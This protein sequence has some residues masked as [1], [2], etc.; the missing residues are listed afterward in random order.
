MLLFATLT[1][2]EHPLGIGSYLRSTSASDVM[3]VRHNQAATKKLVTID[4]SA[5]IAEIVTGTLIA[6]DNKMR[7]LNT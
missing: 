3:T 2:G 1:A 6:S 7:F 5:T 4:E